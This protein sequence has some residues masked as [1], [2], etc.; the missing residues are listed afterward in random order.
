VEQDPPGY[1]SSASPWTTSKAARRLDPRD[2]L[3]R[4]Q[5]RRHIFERSMTSRRSRFWV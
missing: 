3:P 1:R 2:C 5:Y 4:Q